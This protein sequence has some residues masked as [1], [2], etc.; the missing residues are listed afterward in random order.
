MERNM[1]GGMFVAF[2]GLDG[3]G[4]STQAELLKQYFNFLDKIVLLTKEPTQWTFAGKKIKRVLDE[5]IAIEPLQLQYLFAGDR[6]VHLRVEIIPA[7]KKGQ[8]VICDRY[9]FSTLAFGGM[10]V[11][12]DRLIELNKSFLYPDLTIFL[13]V[14][15]EICLQRIEKRGE[16]IKFFEKL[17]KLEKIAAIYDV[18]CEIMPRVIIVNGEESIAEIHKKIQSAIKKSAEKEVRRC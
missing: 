3:S 4:Q 11:S 16:G 9:F 2:E 13:K 5:E 14:R 12:I 1:H 15:P 8:I 7:L 17:E 6:M 10:N 18:I